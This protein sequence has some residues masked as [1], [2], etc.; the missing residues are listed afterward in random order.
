ME[1]LFKYSTC[2]ILHEINNFKKY[3]GQI[4]KIYISLALIY[5]ISI[6]CEVW[7][8]QHGPEQGFGA[9]AAPSQG[10]WLEQITWNF[11]SFDVFSKVNINYDLYVLVHVLER[12]L[13][14]L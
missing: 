14:N 5:S 1:K 11:T 8:I 2:I 7:Y 12:I 13:D 3:F 4:H 6:W 9:G 10:I